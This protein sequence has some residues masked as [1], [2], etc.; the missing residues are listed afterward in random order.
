MNSMLRSFF[1]I[2]V[3]IIIKNLPQSHDDIYHGLDGIVIAFLKSIRGSC[4][5]RINV[6]IRALI[7]NEI[8]AQQSYLNHTIR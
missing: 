4:S 3:F 5:S 6:K 8:C 7:N 1:F 2:D